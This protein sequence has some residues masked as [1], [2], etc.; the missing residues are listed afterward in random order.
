MCIVAIMLHVTKCPCVDLVGICKQTMGPGE[1]CLW[2]EGSCDTEQMLFTIPWL[3]S[4][5][6]EVAGGDSTK[7]FKPLQRQLFFIFLWDDKWP[8]GQEVGSEGSDFRFCSGQHQLNSLCS[9]FHHE[10]ASGAED[11]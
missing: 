1:G 2:E 5:F 6:W 3:Q 7:S 10:T 4:D 11:N 8:A 9:L